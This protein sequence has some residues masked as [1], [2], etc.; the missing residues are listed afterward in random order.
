MVS[1]SYVLRYAYELE[2]VT[3]GLKSNGHFFLV[4]KNYSLTIF[5]LKYFFAKISIDYSLPQ[6]N[7][8]AQKL[9]TYSKINFLNHLK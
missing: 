3:A 7:Y 2:K 8:S 1:I 5:A 9:E 4:P 6:T